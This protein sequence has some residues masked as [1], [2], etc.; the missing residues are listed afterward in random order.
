VVRDIKA[1]IVG[2]FYNVATAGFEGYTPGSIVRLTGANLKFDPARSDEGVF[3]RGE[4]D[5]TRL[6]IYSAIGRRQVDGL[7]PATVSGARRVIVRTR[8]TPNGDLREGRLARA[9]DQM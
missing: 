8:Y 4:A 7:V 5:E 3:L 1:P 2:S 9:V 6:M